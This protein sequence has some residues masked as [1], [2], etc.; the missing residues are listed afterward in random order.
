MFSFH[1]LY[2]LRRNPFTPKKVQR[3]EDHALPNQSFAV[4]KIL[5]IVYARSRLIAVNTQDITCSNHSFY[6]SSQTMLREGNVFIGVCPFTG[7]GRKWAT[8]MYYGI[9]HM[10]AVA[11]PGFPRGGVTNSWG[12][13]NIWSCQIFPK[14]A[15]NWKN[16]G[17]Q[18][19]RASLAPP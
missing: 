11:D 8:S 5:V 17:P 6:Y 3:T 10:I 1:Y 4:I 19:G 15:W 7:V 16:L 9:E 14:T 13:A 2:F 18:G 12:G